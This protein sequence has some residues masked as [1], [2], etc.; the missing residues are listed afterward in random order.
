MPQSIFAKYAHQPNKILE[1]MFKHRTYHTIHEGV[2][3]VAAYANFYPICYHDH[4]NNIQ[5]LDVEIV[6][7]FAHITN[8]KLN[9]IEIKTWNKIWFAAHQKKA[10]LAIGGIGISDK[11]TNSSTEW[12]IPYFYVY[13]T[14]VY[15]KKD[16]IYKFPD[17]VNGIILGVLGSTGFLDAKKRLQSIKKQKY[18]KPGSTDDHDIQQLLNRDVKGILRGSFVGQALVKKY[19]HQLGMTSPWKIHKDMVSKDGEVFAFPCHK[20]SGLASV[21]S[22]FITMLIYNGTFSSFIENSIKIPFHQT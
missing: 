12:T 15:N 20:S 11:R 1:Y 8:L 19:K 7:L 21:L 17:Q 3:T 14:L 9:I 4:Y 13:R 16:P 10:D 18:L 6:K 22:A 5:G 2:L